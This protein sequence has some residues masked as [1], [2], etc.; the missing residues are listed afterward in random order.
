MSTGLT[1][2]VQHEGGKLWT[3][4]KVVGQGSDDHN[5]R[6]YKVMVMKTGRIS[7]RIK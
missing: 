7:M 3:H 2:A 6:L 5:G 1:V 4:G